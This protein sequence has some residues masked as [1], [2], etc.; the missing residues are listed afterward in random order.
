MSGIATKTQHVVEI[1][2]L[3]LWYDQTMYCDVCDILILFLRT[4]E[5]FAKTPSCSFTKNYYVVLSVRQ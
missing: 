2:T 4:W 3:N 5:D 1:D